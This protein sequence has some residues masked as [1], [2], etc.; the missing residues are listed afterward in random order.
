ML[1]ILIA[2]LAGVVLCGIL[3]AAA[4]PRGGCL[5]IL[6]SFLTLL[7]VGAILIYGV[8]GGSYLSAKFKARVINAELGTSYTTEEVFF[9]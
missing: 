2:I 8:F 4:A 5:E 7:I 9:A 6:A 1:M 3:W